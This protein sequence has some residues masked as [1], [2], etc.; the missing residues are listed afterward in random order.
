M[1]FLRWVAWLFVS[2]PAFVIGDNDAVEVD[3]IETLDSSAYNV[4]QE[5][6]HE[7]RVSTYSSIRGAAQDDN[8]N[9]LDNRPSKKLP[10]FENG[11]VIFFLHTPKTGGTT[12]R[13][14]VQKLD[15]VDYYFG[16][17]YSTYWDTAP[18]V[19]D[20]ILHGTHNKSILFLEIHAKD[21]PSLLR[22]RKRLK[23]WRDTAA[24]NKVS[25]FFFTV[26][27]DSLPY[28]LSH[29]NFFHV[30]KRNPTFEQC[31]AT[32]ENFLRLSL[33]NPQ[34]Q[35]LANGEASMRAQKSKGVVV[36]PETCEQVYETFSES[37]DWVG[38]TERLS[39]E[40][41]PLLSQLLELP[42]NF[43]FFNHRITKKEDG[44]TF[45]M[46]NLTS[47]ALDSVLLGTTVDTMLYERTLRDFPFSRWD[48]PEQP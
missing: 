24:H 31:N 37:L 34:C 9:T 30:Q 20:A 44:T 3:F 7:D 11:G 46:Q 42:S 10:S 1:I 28:A 48:I 27:R 40:T 26:L 38:T 45:E 41:L 35:F 43:T 39:N 4:I 16:T 29:F 22:L 25:V 14:N 5:V 8:K 33:S 19:E 32:E 12:I 2:L 6:I 18:L 13:L 47:T 36:Q 15:R 23:R 17:N 21:S